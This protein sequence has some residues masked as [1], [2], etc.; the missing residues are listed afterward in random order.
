MNGDAVRRGLEAADR[1]LCN[2][3]V[4][5]CHQYDREDF[6]NSPGVKLNLTPLIC[7]I[8]HLKF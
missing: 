4:H 8:E 7:K 3:S 2:V 1:S 5:V 6:L